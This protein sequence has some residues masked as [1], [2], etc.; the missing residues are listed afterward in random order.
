[1]KYVSIFM[2]G[3]LKILYANFHLFKIAY[4]IYT[5]DIFKNKLVMDQGIDK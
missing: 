1:M 4:G 3:N 2:N 5:H